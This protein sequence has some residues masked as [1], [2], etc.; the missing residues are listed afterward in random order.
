MISH[1]GETMTIEER[2]KEHGLILAAPFK[3]PSGTPYPFS[4]VRVRGNRAYIA[5]HL[6]L[7]P[8]GSLAEPRGK[9]GDM[10]SIE[11][12][13]RLARLA[14]LAMLGSL[15]RELGDL[16]RVAAWLRVLVM[17]NTAPAT[18]QLAGIANGFSDLILDLY[19]RDRGAHSRSAIG[20]AEL[21][22]AVAV[23]I[24]AE[25]EIA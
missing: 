14:G 18:P 3:S 13:A 17:V 19:G 4:W 6:P 24:E 9:V 11:Q 23:E 8:D 12:G 7:R 5:G 16:D 20:V 10:I 22:F 21:P 2:L 1:M 15:Q 25:I